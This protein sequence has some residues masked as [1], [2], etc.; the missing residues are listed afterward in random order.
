MGDEIIIKPRTLIVDLDNSFL[1]QNL[2]FEAIINLIRHNLIFFF[3]AL[4]ILKKRGLV[5]FK[6]Y[7]FKKCDFSKISFLENKSVFD[8]IES[9]KN[10]DCLIFLLTGSSNFVARRVARFYKIFDGFRGS[11]DQNMTGEKK[12]FFS[13]TKNFTGPI[14]YIGDSIADIPMWEWSDQ[15]IVVNPSWLVKR[16]LDA[17]LVWHTLIDGTNKISHFITLMRPFHWVK[18]ILVV[19]PLLFADRVPVYNFIDLLSALI[20]FCICSSSGYIINDIFDISSDRNSGLKKVR[21]IAAGLVKIENAVLL[22]L[23]LIFFV[24]F[25]SLFLFDSSWLA[26]IF[27]LYLCI[28]TCYSIWLK[29]VV[30]LDVFC[31][32]VL[33]WFRLIAG[34]FVLGIELSFAFVFVL[35]CPLLAFLCIK[36]VGEIALADNCELYVVGRPYRKIDIDSFV[37]IASALIVFWVSGVYLYCYHPSSGL[38]FDEPAWLVFASVIISFNLIRLLVLARGRS[39]RIDLIKFAGFDLWTVLGISVV[40][41]SLWL[42]EPLSLQAIK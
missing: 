24:L 28:S 12:V 27:S 4:I 11:I 35:S 20:L 36:R 26:L 25:A 40:F 13:Q 33:N 6:Y 5:T 8:F 15:R 31:V 10:N 37:W 39:I 2:L 9:N 29:Q 21:P 41:A 1:K 14:C 32:L 23:I 30:F 7:V 18:N 16:K 19:L 22:G 3:Y 34:S 17:D 38:R 42:A